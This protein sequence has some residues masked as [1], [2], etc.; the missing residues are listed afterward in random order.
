M[1]I[2]RY[3]DTILE[4]FLLNK[5]SDD[6]VKKYICDK[7]FMQELIFTTGDKA[8]YDMCDKNVKNDFQFNIN[9]LNFFRENLK[10]FY[11]IY[12]SYITNSD[13]FH[14][15]QLV[16]YLAL[17][18]WVNEN[19]KLSNIVYLA[20][21]LYKTRIDDYKRR[22]IKKENFFGIGFCF[23]L[24]SYSNNSYAKD[25]CAKKMA[26]DL[27]DKVDLDDFYSSKFKSATE[28][29][30]YGTNNCILLLIKDY[31]I[32]LHDYLIGHIY[33]VKSLQKKVNELIYNWQSLGKFNIGKNLV[34]FISS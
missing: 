20:E 5:L 32:F 17:Q 13:Q 1:Y 8:I 9:L 30:G 6:D 26:I 23:I 24:D 33:L 22:I 2:K 31:D 12:N 14:Q 21:M 16:F 34:R 28:M 4:N 27:F 11:Y 7:N 10:S 19:P 29:A 25:F 15:H 18:D 3:N